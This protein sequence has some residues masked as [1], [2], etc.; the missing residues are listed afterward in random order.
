MNYLRNPLNASHGIKRD[1]ANI[2]Q[3]VTRR[4]GVYGDHLERVVVAD[5]LANSMLGRF[6]RRESNEIV[7][8]LTGQLSQGCAIRHGHAARDPPLLNHL[9]TRYFELAGHLRKTPE[10]RDRALQGF[11]RS[12]MF[13][14]FHENHH[15][16]ERLAMQVPPALSQE[17]LA[18]TIRA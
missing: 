16:Q 18:H 2:A 15:I 12:G 17:T 7:T 13:P 9:I 4:G 1:D 5:A 8:I 10:V 6:E 11:V 3:T 14:C